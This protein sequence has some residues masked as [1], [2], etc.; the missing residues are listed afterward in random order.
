MIQDAI[1]HYAKNNNI[2]M[3]DGEKYSEIHK[4]ILKS[5]PKLHSRRELKELSK[6]LLILLTN[7]Y[8]FRATRVF[9]YYPAI[10]TKNYVGFDEIH[11]YQNI[12]DDMTK[13]AQKFMKISNITEDL[14][15]KLLQYEFKKIYHNEIGYF[16]LL[17]NKHV[18]N[19]IHFMELIYTHSYDKKYIKFLENDIKIDLELIGDKYFTN[20]DLTVDKNIRLLYDVCGISY[21]FYGFRED[22][23]LRYDGNGNVYVDK[24]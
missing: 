20:L 7:K 3:K 6:S 17:P 10:S 11:L 4:R 16:P 23:Y 21:G 13:T 5:N 12:Y 2:K 14:D 22:V 18:D 24:E 19:L 1:Y 9:A 8:G 15:K